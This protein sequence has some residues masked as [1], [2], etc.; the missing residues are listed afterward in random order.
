MH[1]VEIS[2]DS[3]SVSGSLIAPPYRPRTQPGAAISTLHFHIYLPLI[4]H[5]FAPHNQGLVRINLQLTHSQICRTSVPTVTR[6]A[7]RN[8]FCKPIVP[9][10][11]EQTKLLAEHSISLVNQAWRVS[12]ATGQISA[13]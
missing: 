7:L 9:K 10:V 4:I 13:R 2:T 11:K 6:R 1:G 3:Y 12:K 5:G 8:S